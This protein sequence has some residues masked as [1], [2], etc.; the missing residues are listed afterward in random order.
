MKKYTL[1]L[2]LLLPMLAVSQDTVSIKKNGY[3]AIM[4]GPSFPV[5]D[6]GD[7]DI[8]NNENAGLA[9]TG[10]SLFLLDF[11]YKFHQNIGITASWVGGAN[12][13]DAQALAD[14]L[15][16]NNGGAWKVESGAY[17]YGGLYV[18]PL[19]TFPMDKVEL[20]VR[21]VIGFASG[22]FPEIK[23]VEASGFR[24]TQSNE[25]ATCVAY[26]IGGGA[27]VHLSKSLSFITRFDYIAMEPETEVTISFPGSSNQDQIVEIKQPMNTLNWNLGIAFRL[28]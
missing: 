21:A 24:Y 11:G 6:Y 5:G 27:R 26:S 18:G 17:S 4:M 7:N 28:K 3:L 12:P 14:V 19:F 16:Q 22:F 10:F 9:K 8:S 2:L 23:V 25:A 20:D 15:A 13:V 1:L